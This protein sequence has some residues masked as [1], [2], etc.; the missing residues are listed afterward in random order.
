MKLNLNN[1]ELSYKVLQI[2]LILEKLEISKI[3]KSKSKRILF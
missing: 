1:S 2:F 3:F